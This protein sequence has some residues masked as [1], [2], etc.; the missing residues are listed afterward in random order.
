MIRHS[1]K[2]PNCE[3]CKLFADER[4]ECSLR[5]QIAIAVLQAFFMKGNCLSYID[6]T[7]KTSYEVADKML[8]ERKK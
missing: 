4:K 5:D 1:C 7:I 6:S 8:K 2:N 3:I